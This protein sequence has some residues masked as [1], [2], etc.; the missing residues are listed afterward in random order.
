MFEKTKNRK[1][2][3]EAVKKVRSQVGT[4]RKEMQKYSGESRGIRFNAYQHA[5]DA[6]DRSFLE[7]CRKI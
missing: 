1:R 3:K 4:V 5:S 6:M 7:A 2:Y